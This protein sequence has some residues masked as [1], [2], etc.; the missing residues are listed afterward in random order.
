MT[1]TGRSYSGICLIGL[2]SEVFGIMQQVHVQRGIDAHTVRLSGT[3]TEPDKRGKFHDDKHYI[4]YA[5]QDRP[6]STPLRGIPGNPDIGAAVC[7]EIDATKPE[8]IRPCGANRPAETASAPARRSGRPRR[9]SAAGDRV[10]AGCL[11]GGE[12]SATTVADRALPWSRPRTTGRPADVSLPS[13]SAWP[14]CHLFPR[15]SRCRP[16]SS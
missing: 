1:R 4:S 8:N 16:V 2:G 15:P 12:S 7:V 14:P 11:A 5:Y 10:T 6:F 13:S 9:N 3:F